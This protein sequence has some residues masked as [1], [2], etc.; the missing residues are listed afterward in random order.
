M[1]TLKQIQSKISSIKNEEKKLS[2]KTVLMHIER[3]EKFYENGV[4]ENDPQYFTDV[5]YRTNQAF[6][7]ILKIA[8]ETLTDQSAN[9]KTPNE[10][11]QYFSQNS[12]LH[13]RVL[14]LFKNYRT[15][16][17][18]PSTHNYKLFFSEEEAYL[19][20]LSV[21]SFINLLLNQIIE[22]LTFL[23]EQELLNQAE[24]EFIKGVP[25]Y[26]SFSLIEKC[27]KILLNFSNFIEENREF[28]TEHELLGS[29]EAY[30][31]KA[32]PSI[33]LIRE[34][35]YTYNEKI[36][37]PDFT[38]EY[39]EEKV[40]LEVK[41]EYRGTREEL[42]Q[43]QLQDYILASGIK[44]GIGYFYTSNKNKT[45]ESKSTSIMDNGH[46]ATVCIIFPK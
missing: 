2:V 37:R 13:S 23:Q 27:E 8:F 21:S 4:N 6:E 31:N 41:K 3:A 46:R 20:I 11:E 15:E 39:H 30:I 35:L 19:A 7:G 5:I 28:A 26:S 18:N 32:D 14:D 12:I 17:R 24:L 43:S 16:W 1:D 29:L 36:F 25:N 38:M 33:N 9:R 44:F 40:L 45:Y 42:I 34:P 22:R 10:I